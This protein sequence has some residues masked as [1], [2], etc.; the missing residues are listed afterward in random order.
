MSNG[1]SVLEQS[2]LVLLL[3]K[4]FEY[5]LSGTTLWKKD[6]KGTEWCVIT[7]SPGEVLLWCPVRE[8][9][10]LNPSVTMSRQM[11]GELFV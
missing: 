6:N 11:F 7:D 2:D 1:E 3:D 10:G 9:G 5:G 4:D 8:N